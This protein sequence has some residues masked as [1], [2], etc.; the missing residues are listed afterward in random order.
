[1][2]PALHQLAR[3]AKTVFVYGMGGG[4][5]VIQT[6]PIRN[7][8]QQL[9]VERV[10]IGGVTCQWWPPPEFDPEPQAPFPLSASVWGPCYYALEEVENGRW[11][12]SQALQVDGSARVGKRIPAEAQMAELFGVE[13]VLLSLRGG[14]QGFLAGL[15]AV[16]QEFAVDL[17][18][19]V[20]IGSD[21]IYS[22]TDEVRQPRTPLADFIS[23]S[24]LYRCS[25]PSIYGLSGYGCDEELALED[26]ERNVGRVMRAGGFLGAYGLTQED[27]A[28]ME[29]ACHAMPDPVE[30]WPMEAAKGNLG[31]HRM[32]LSEPWG[33]LLRIT[34]LQAMILFFD[35]KI[36]VA[37]VNRIAAQVGE[38]GSLAEAEAT[39]AQ[40]GILP[41]SYL[42]R[43]IQFL[44]PELYGSAGSAS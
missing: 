10:I 12:G 5:D 40:A 35:P 18:V 11:M 2:L 44:R 28:D 32:R 43:Y 7:Y 22:H 21:S 17:V 38:T 30:K 33:S 16:I 34:P 9:G 4:G 14:G 31:L 36:L 26:L 27:V 39:L 3:S 6:I 23:L 19:G 37:A 8:L 41:E 29:R 1:M 25:V 24:G 20:D 42:Q 15:E 13:A